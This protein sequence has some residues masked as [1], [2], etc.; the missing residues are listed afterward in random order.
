[1]EKLLV[2]FSSADQKLEAILQTSSDLNLILDPHGVVLAYKSSDPSLPY[3]ISNG[4]LN[5]SIQ[6][7]FSSDLARRLQDALQSVQQ[8][9]SVISLEYPMSIA[10][11]EYWFDA[12]LIP[13]SS[14]Q[15]ML[16]ARDM[17]KC[18]DIETKM[19]RKV[20]QLSALRSIDLAIASGLDLNLLLSMPRCCWT[21]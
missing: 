19:E 16:T 6:D 21:V 3:N 5:Q 2:N 4:I 8:T 9:G 18:K 1:M 17:T 13:I 20:Q 11:R 7:I 10:N 15:I 14:S 12:R